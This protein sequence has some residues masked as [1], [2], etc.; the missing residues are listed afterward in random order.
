[1][2][3][4]SIIFIVFLTIGFIYTIVFFIKQYNK[5]SYVLFDRASG[6][7]EKPFYLELSANIKGDYSIYYTLDSSDPTTD[8]ILYTDPIYIDG[9]SLY[10][11]IYTSKRFTPETMY[12]IQTIYMETTGDDEK[13]KS[14]TE[15]V[16]N[17]EEVDSATVVRAICVDKNGRKSDVRT[18]VYFVGILQKNEFDGISVISIVTDPQNLFGNKEGIYVAGEDFDN[19][20]DKYIDWENF[21]SL[22]WRQ[23]ILWSD[24]NYRNTGLDSERKCNVKFFIDDGEGKHLVNDGNIGLRISGYGSR[25][26]NHKG[27][28]LFARKEYYDDIYESNCVN[29]FENTENSLA[30]YG[31]GD[32]KLTLLKFYLVNELVGSEVV[33]Y[34]SFIPSYMFIDGHFWGMYWIKQRLDSEFFDNMFG[35][36]DDCLVYS[37]NWKYETGNEQKGTQEIEEFRTIRKSLYNSRYSDDQYHELEQLVDI[38]NMIDYYALEIYIAN[39]DWPMNNYGM[40]KSCYESNESNYYDGRW[41]YITFDVD[42]GMDIENYELDF[43][44]VVE[45]DSL[46]AYMIQ[47]EGFYNKLC[48]KLIDYAENDLAPQKVK[49]FTDNYKIKM[50]PY[51]SKYYNRF[52]VGKD[53]ND[54]YAE[55]D[56]ITNFFEKRHDYIIFR[57][58]EMLDE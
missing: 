29:V 3:K 41:R 45:S 32:D 10:D 36:R 26:N 21:N 52:Y 17:D 13:N 46:F 27:F 11:N 37:K 7:Y 1:M 54:F 6:F 34:N 22:D 47:N 58:G 40:W 44:R 28:N 8:S 33:C 30:L 35:I 24:G 42:S 53:I 43:Q 14:Y 38:D 16:V 39:I 19:S 2:K 4:K 23:F 50:S 48:K 55:C 15:S 18:E 51:I 57:Y 20:L 49:S 12:E 25:V 56:K 5:A 31:G 9:T